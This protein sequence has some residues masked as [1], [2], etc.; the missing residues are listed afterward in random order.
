MRIL[1]G[2]ILSFGCALAQQTNRLT[3]IPTADDSAVGKI[4]FKELRSNGS[5]EICLKTSNSLGS[6]SDIDVSAL[7]SYW[8][9]SG[10]TLTTTTAND[11]VDLAAGLLKFSAATGAKI[12]LFESSSTEKYGFSVAS[13]SMRIHRD[14]NASKISFGYGHAGAYTE[15]A[16]ITS[17]EM[18]VA[19]LFLNGN[20]GVGFKNDIIPDADNTRDIGYVLGN[21]GFKD[22]LLKGVLMVGGGGI[23]DNAGTLQCSNDRSTWAACGGGATAAGDDNDI[24]YKLSGALAGNSDFEWNNTTKRLYVNDTSTGSGDFVKGLFRRTVGPVVVDLVADGNYASNN[25]QVRLKSFSGSSSNA[26]AV[27]NGTAARGSESSPSAT[28][29][30]ETMF[31]INGAG[32]GTSLFNAN[33]GIHFIA[34]STFSGS[35]GEAY[36]VFNTTASGSTSPAE[37]FRATSDKLLKFPASTGGK[38]VLYE[39]SSTEKYGLS[40]AAS[41]FRIHRDYSASKISFGYGHA[42]SY[43]ENAFL[44][45]TY[46]DF[47]SLFLDG[48]GGVTFADHILPSADNTHDIGY[49]LGN[50]GFKDLLLK[51]TAM[52][53]S[54][55]VRY[56]GGNLQWSHDRS[57][58]N[59]FSTGGA[60]LPVTDS[61]SIVEGSSDATKEVRIEVDTN[62]SSGT[63]RV[64]TAQNTNLT[65]AG[66]DVAQTFTA[67]QTF[68]GNILASGT[69]EIGSSGTPFDK[70]YSTN[71]YVANFLPCTACSNIIDVTGHLVTSAARNLGGT[72]TEWVNLYLTGVVN[73]DGTNGVTASGASCTITAINGGIITGATC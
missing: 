59:N 45:S 2:V 69:R 66:I 31:Q 1:L 15:Q 38:I 57:S 9:R 67:N 58:W 25:A 52:I 29:S 11:S 73:V 53:G 65:V 32:Y 17:G 5:N 49:I 68:S 10:T 44:N 4:C 22:I 16:W 62:L 50:S 56:S 48:N 7:A 28:Q 23:R 55:G 36:I 21:S 51:G 70:T 43:T 6:S 8:S 47:K 72:F 64:W 41:D 39:S 19:S 26:G 63:V 27:I 20:G 13:G 12:V 61:T 37:A 24:Q 54:G 71:V 42:G 30:G 18:N 40:V 33:A 60:S 14:F 46:F 35:N 34:G 3:V